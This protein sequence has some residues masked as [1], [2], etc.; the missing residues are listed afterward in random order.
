MMDSHFSFEVPVDVVTTRHKDASTSL[1]I[2]EMTKGMI[3]MHL[4][5]AARIA[6][7]WTFF[8]AL[9]ETFAARVAAET[10]GWKLLE[11]TPS[12]QQSVIVFLSG[13]SPH[14]RLPK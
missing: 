12:L 5:H 6:D 2:G 13:A 9:P 10:N 11:R 4:Q 7:M 14:G 1:A 8:A 3:A